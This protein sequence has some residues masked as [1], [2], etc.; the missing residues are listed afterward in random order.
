MGSAGDRVGRRVRLRR[1]L[2]RRAPCS[3]VGAAPRAG[4][5]DAGRA[6]AHQEHPHRPRR[7]PDALLPPRRAGQPHLAARSHQPRA[8][9]L[10]RGRQR[11]AQRLGDVRR[12]RHGRREPRDDP[13]IR[14]VHHEPVDPGAGLDPRRQALEGRSAPRHARH[15]PRAAPQ[16]PPAAA[17]ADRRGRAELA[18]A[19]ARDGRREGLAAAQPEPEPAV[20]ERPLG[21]LRGRGAA[22]GPRG[23][24]QRLA[25]G[26]RGV[27]GPPPTRKPGSCPTAG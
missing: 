27:R 24:P 9:E 11:A 5:P 22:G 15:G 7:L 12:G 3:Q 1:S 21:L 17:S 20:R 16:A 2:D 8:A 23:A 25:H 26:A 19:D 13:G 6:A 4:P 18:L 14:R 10:R